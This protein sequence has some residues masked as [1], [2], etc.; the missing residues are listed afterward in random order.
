MD[1]RFGT[2]NVRIFYRAGSLKTVASKLAKYSLDLVVVQEVWWD[3]GGSEVADK[4]IFF[5]GNENANH[6]SRTGFFIHMEII[7]A[8][9]RVKFIM[10]C[11]V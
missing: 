2:W 10:G 4:F 8:A 11:C 3:S 1:M 5:Y 7:S 9:E 6:L